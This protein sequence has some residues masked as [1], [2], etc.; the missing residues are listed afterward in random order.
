MLKRKGI[1]LAGGLGTRLYPNTYVISKQLLPLY[2]KPTIY[3]PLSTLMLAGINEIVFIS[4]PQHVGM[5]RELLGDGAK[6]GCKFEY[7]EQPRPSGI[8]EALI[9]AADFLAGSPSALILGDNVFYGQGLSME[10]RKA[11]DTCD[12]ATIFATKVAEPHRYG[13]VETDVNGKAISIAEKPDNPLSNDAVVG[14]YF[15]DNTAPQRAA[16]LER[17]N[18]GELEIT[19]LNLSYLEDDKLNCINLSRGITWFDM[20][21]PSSMIESASFVRTVEE[22]DG[23]LICSPEEIAW[24]KNFISE[25]DFFELIEQMPDSYYREKL[26]A[27]LR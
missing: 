2:S 13:I 21:T 20:G 26:K 6:L 10:L 15:Y 11:S 19:D 14:L 16:T 18:R 9:L 1:I 4:S 8:A 27:K 5:F 7:V 22:R 17:S 12:G 23:R 24:V 25:Q 3:Y